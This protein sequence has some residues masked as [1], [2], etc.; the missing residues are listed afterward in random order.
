M[1]YSGMKPVCCAACAGTLA[2]GAASADLVHYEG[3]ITGA[4]PG[5]ELMASEAGKLVQVPFEG[6]YE[7]KGGRIQSPWIDLDKEAGV[8]A[9]YRLEFTAKTTDHCY[10]WVDFQDA[11]GQSLPDINSA[12]YAGGGEQ[13]YDQMIYV[14][15]SAAKMQLAFQSTTGVAVRDLAVRRVSDAEAAAWCDRV[16]T[17]L[18]PLNF[19]PPADAFALL[20]R[21]AAALREG[22]PWRVVMLG[23]SIQNDSFNSVFQSLVKR[24]YPESKLDFVISV[25]G[26]TG[27]WFYENPENFA[28]YVAKHKPDLLLIG[29]ISNIRA[30]SGTVQENF[31]AIQRVVEQAQALG[32]EVALL[33]PPHSVDWRPLDIAKPEAALPAMAWSEETLDSKGIRRLRWTL[34]RDL[35]QECGIAFWNITVPMVDYVA[36]SCKPHDWFN[37]DTVHNNDRGKQIIGRVLQCY[38]RTAAHVR[39]PPPEVQAVYAKDPVTIDGRLD[40]AVWALAPAYE[41]Q[42]GEDR[43]VN[44]AVL[45]EPGRVRFAWNENYLYA[46]FEFTDSDVVAE[47][48]EDGQH[49]YSLGDVAELFLWPDA[50]TWY[51]ELYATPHGKQSSFFFPSPGRMLPSTFKNHLHLQV[52]AEV[53]GTFNDWSDRDHGWTVEMAIPVQ[54][55]TARGEA[56]GLDASWRVL[57]GRYNYSVHLPK[58]ELSAMPLLSNTNYHLRDQYAFLKL[59][60][61][62]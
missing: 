18:P 17:A 23:D 24:D 27:C 60:R 13:V 19:E 62:D 22:K 25:R 35:A 42:L 40:D 11:A 50:H 52:A 33:S 6:S 38:F 9:Y 2:V 10:W 5:W 49:H 43:A 48:K 47:G 57:V 15:G 46:A 29:G 28:E 37:R 59:M 36:A 53:Q 56:W 31:D 7:S 32:C 54:E 44:G 4:T 20:P 3:E 30:E 45:R 34:F 55:I 14:V 39:M 51:W 21:T 12:V 1:R 58:A 26:S 16:Y 41:L 8:P 61:K